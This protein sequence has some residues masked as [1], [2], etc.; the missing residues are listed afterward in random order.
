MVEEREDRFGE[1]RCAGNL[2]GSARGGEPVVVLP[3]VRDI[4]PM[5]KRGAEGDG[6]PRVMATGFSQGPGEE[7]DGREAVPEPRLAD[8]IGDVD[9]GIGAGGFARIAAGGGEPPGAGQVR[10]LFPAFG[11][12]GGKDQERVGVRCEDAGMGLQNGRVLAGMGRACRPDRAAIQTFLPAF[13]GFGICVGWGDRGLEVAGG[14]ERGVLGQE[15]GEAVPGRVI[16]RENQ[17]EEAEDVPCRGR[18]TGPGSDA[19]CRQAG[20]DEG[21]GNSADMGPA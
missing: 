12:A 5:K 9:L 10:D 18:E 2:A 16:L 6:L 20:V 13:Q 19:L 14:A 4:G 11:V 15:A 21:K 3:G 7:S 8:R 1:A 17:I